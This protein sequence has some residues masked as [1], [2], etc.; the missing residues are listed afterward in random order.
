MFWKN[1]VLHGMKV[2]SYHVQLTKLRAELVGGATLLQILWPNETSR[3]CLRWLR[4]RQSENQLPHI[5]LGCRVWFDPAAVQNYLLKERRPWAP[6]TFEDW[7]YASQVSSENP[8]PDCL[9][10]AEELLPLFWPRK[11][12]R[13][14]LRWLRT[15]ER[16]GEIPSVRIGRLVWFNPFL[17]WRSVCSR[18]PV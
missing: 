1:P 5:R 12:E 11:S 9:V 13:P 7:S 4:S 15:R 18:S 6:S 16:A 10:D 8:F 17:V 3:P 2:D 14:C